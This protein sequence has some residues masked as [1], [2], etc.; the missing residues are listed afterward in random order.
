[1]RVFKTGAIRDIVDGKL[2]YIR[3]LSPIVL[4]R[5]L[6]YLDKHRLQSDGSLR[7]FD[8]WKHGIGQDVYMDSLG[9]HFMDMWLL[10]SGFPTTDNHGSVDKES[11][12]CAIM[13]NAM[14]MLHE[15]LKDIK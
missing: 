14:G 12:L 6:Q 7:E 9:R 3:G 4:R 13:F 11:V 10:H 8:N 5:Y 15:I 1:M 2:S